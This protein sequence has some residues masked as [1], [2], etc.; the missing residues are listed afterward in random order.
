MDTSPITPYWLRALGRDEGPV[1]VEF[2]GRTYRR[3]RIFKHD[4]FAYTAS[5]ADGENRVVLKVGRVASLFGLPL[6]WIGRLHAAHE[7]AAFE[8]LQD[9]SIVPRFIG[10]YGRHGLAHAFVPGHELE[11]G[12]RV[13]DD[14]FDHLREGLATIHARGMA[15]V[16]LEKCENVL[17]GDD[18]QPYLFDFQIAWHLPRRLGGEIWPFT[19]L[20][21][22][23]QQADRYHVQKLQRRTRPDQ[24]SP[25][26]IEDSRRRPTHVR[27][28][29]SLTRPF[30]ALRRFVL[31]RIDPVKKRGERG[32]VHLS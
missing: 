9:L 14:F 13:P 10:R 16:D 1:T 28:Y 5:Y 27:I 15:Y 3:E 19:M 7:A 24:M 22:F 30:I 32:R 6:S 31:N 11:R 26:E 20:R 25:R 21:R 29:S 12:E 18:G 2:G 23:F 17:V 8:A 4:F